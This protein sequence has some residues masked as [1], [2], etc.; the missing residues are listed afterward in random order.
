[1]SSSI[2]L[3][4]THASSV[5]DQSSQSGAQPDNTMPGMRRSSR[6]KVAVIEEKPLGRC[7]GTNVKRSNFQTYGIIM[8]FIRMSAYGLLIG[9]LGKWP[10]AQAGSCLGLSVLYLI[11]LRFAVPYSRRDEMAL[12]YWVALLDIII[13]ALLL[14][15]DL[16]IDDDD[17]NG[18]DTFCIVLLV[19]QG[20][21]MLSY[22]INRVL[23]VIHAFAEVVC[24]ACSCG[25]PSPT[26]DSKR[27][28][29]HR[30][31][32]S[33]GST[34]SR[35]ESL[36]YSASDTS[37]GMSQQFFADGKGYYAHGAGDGKDVDS[38]SGPHDTATSEN[39]NGYAYAAPPQ[40]NG[41]AEG[42]SVSRSGK[43]GMF[44]AIIEEETDLQNSE[45][46]NTVN[47]G[48]SSQQKRGQNAVFDKFWRSL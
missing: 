26:K 32:R 27:R 19:F 12:E 25:A 33:G 44:P 16:S 48:E 1:M 13:F 15:L 41:M 36:T 31:S 9:S 20:L 11:Y 3:R 17:F 22:L 2:P 14:A 7:C 21:G 38:I 37:I 40:V 24:P 10:A 28:S 5:S 23:I 29:K 46:R 35:S 39:E 6:K 8:S 42:R 43:S 34:F 30:K 18:M 4:R 47:P 45:S